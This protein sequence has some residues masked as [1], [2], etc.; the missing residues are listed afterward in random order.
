MQRK[1]I[2]FYLLIQLADEDFSKFQ[3][4]FGMDNSNLSEINRRKPKSSQ[5]IGI[6]SLII[7]IFDFFKGYE[8][9]Y[10]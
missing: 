10:L 3:F 6:Y 5:A 7:L 9:F 4:I 8:Q 1:E 2:N